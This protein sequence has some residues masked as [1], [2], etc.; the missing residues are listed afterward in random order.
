[1]R[2]APTALILALA[3]AAPAWARAPT[4]EE[5]ARIEGALRAAG[6]ETWGTVEVE[7]QDDRIRVTGARRTP[8]GP[9]ADVVVEPTTMRVTEE[10]ASRGAG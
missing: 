5:T 10:A 3:I 4:P 1:M 2:I 8:D 6:Y 7:S 9:T